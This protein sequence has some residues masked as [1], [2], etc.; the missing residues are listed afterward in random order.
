MLAGAK[1]CLIACAYLLRC[2]F[3]LNPFYQGHLHSSIILV[4][5][6]LTIS[7]PCP[8]NDSSASCGNAI[9]LQRF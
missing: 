7:K 3:G 6:A 2:V 9:S 1:N 4:S 5:R 8:D